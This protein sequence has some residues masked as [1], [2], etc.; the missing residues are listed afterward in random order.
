M[1]VLGEIIYKKSDGALG[2]LGTIVTSDGHHL[3]WI[4]SWRL[5]KMAPLQTAMGR[6]AG[7]PAWKQR[8][9]CT[10]TQLPLAETIPLISC[11]YWAI[12]H[13]CPQSPHAQTL[14]QGSSQT[15]HLSLFFFHIPFDISYS[16]DEISS[17]LLLHAPHSPSSP[18]TLKPNSEILGIIPLSGIFFGKQK[19][20][21]LSHILF[22]LSPFSWL[23]ER[24]KTCL[25]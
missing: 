7:V 10:E 6:R 11:F 13:P 2:D 4:S 18:S 9:M 15:T 22:F 16:S 12:P 19:Q 17:S 1:Y 5:T 24:E 3:C 23:W 21:G 8:L 14:S 20:G 25:S